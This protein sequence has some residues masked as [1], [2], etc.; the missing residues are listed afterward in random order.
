[1]KRI[2]VS[3][4]VAFMAAG[5]VFAQL[6]PVGWAPA[7]SPV[8]Q[9]GRLKVTGNQMQSASGTQVQLKGMSFFWSSDSEWSHKFYNERVVAWLVSDWRVSVVRA[10]MGVSVSDDGPTYL[11]PGGEARNKDL[12]NK[13]VRA[14]I[15]QGIY[16]I[17]DWH[18][19][20]AENE[21]AAAIA[22][23]EDMA[24]TYK[25][26]PN[27]IY[28]IYNEPVGTNWGTVKSY[29]EAVIDAI[30]RIDPHG[31]VLVGTPQWCQ[32][33]NDPVGNPITGR[34]NVMYTVHFYCNHTFQNA[35]NTAAASQPFFASEIGYSHSS[36]DGSC[37]TGGVDHFFAT[38]NDRKISWAAWSITNKNETASAITTS[39]V[40]S[41]AHNRVSFQTS[42]G[43]GWADSD[44]TASG[45]Y[46]RAKTREGSS[47]SNR[48]YTAAVTALG[49]GTVAGTG[50][51]D[52]CATTNLT[53]NP[54]A[55]SRF[56][57]WIINGTPQGANPLPLEMCSDKEGVAV[58]FPN[59]LLQNST[60]TLGQSGWSV[61][62]GPGATGSGAASNGEYRV[63]VATA[64]AT[65]SPR[66]LRL[67]Q[68]GVALTQGRRYNLSFKARAV[69]PRKITPVIANASGTNFM[70]TS[71]IDLT[72]T[73]KEFEM[74]FNYNAATVTNA[75]AAFYCGS[76]TGDWFIDDV[77]LLDIG[78]STSVDLPARPAVSAAR[79]FGAKLAGQALSLTG[80]GMAEVTI[81]D[82]SGRLRFSQSVSLAN[83]S[84]QVSLNR[85][86]A[87]VYSARYRVDG[88]VMSRNEKILLTK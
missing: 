56:E 55:G 72:V 73:M 85:L 17:I 43:S 69:A 37:G 78:P 48:R 1:M 86:P 31:I 62:Q 14:A 57:G 39:A 21:R 15:D 42:V 44:L 34:A 6:P 81:Y 10:A 24:R 38:L 27:V 35:L 77:S 82:M 80:S 59:N 9:Y 4:A 16:V 75:V 8:A 2:I 68:T 30:R 13:V 74:A 23:F 25:D 67:Q 61:V 29:A 79:P 22:F 76:A 40:N 83:G 26:Y 66:N 63:T 46:W 20:N 50:T 52:V 28:E 51:F 49:S 58:F 53:P 64:A 84:A 41:A 19:H 70:D 45:R 60:F 11:K 36:G 32:N 3:L 7:G 33:V 12:V 18:S 71:A 47:G 5:S 88:K 54:G 87:G 65:T